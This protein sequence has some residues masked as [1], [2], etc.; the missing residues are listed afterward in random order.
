MCRKKKWK[1]EL[2]LWT[3]TKTDRTHKNGAVPYGNRPVFCCYAMKKN[4][5]LTRKNTSMPLFANT[6]PNHFP[7]GIGQLPQ[8]MRQLSFS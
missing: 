6:V 5:R 1:P 3:G 2:P 7:A 4:R 8:N